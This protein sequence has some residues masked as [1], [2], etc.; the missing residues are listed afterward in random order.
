MKRYTFF[1]DLAM[2]ERVK[3]EV[4]KRGFDSVSSFL[5]KLITDYFNEQSK[6]KL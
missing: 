4:R 6:P 5:R 1:V 2:L 3:K